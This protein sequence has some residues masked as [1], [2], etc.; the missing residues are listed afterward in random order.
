M[1]L[2]IYECLSVSIVAL[3]VWLYTRWEYPKGIL[4][5]IENSINLG[6]VVTA[7]W[8]LGGSYSAVGNNALENNSRMIKY[9]A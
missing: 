4:A 2:R 3:C 6:F 7:T 8:G 1:Y 5:K 9:S